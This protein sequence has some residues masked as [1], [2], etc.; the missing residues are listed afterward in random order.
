[1]A[2]WV[3]CVHCKDRISPDPIYNM[4]FYKV[5]DK[6]GL[7]AE[8]AHMDCVWRNLGLIK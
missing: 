6:R 3:T 7:D 8:Y 1:M 4:N 2:T 5:N